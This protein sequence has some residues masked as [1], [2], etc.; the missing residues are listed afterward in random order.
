MLLPLIYSMKS[1]GVI[2]EY[3][4]RSSHI[5]TT[6]LIEALPNTRDD[7]L[8]AIRKFATTLYLKLTKNDEQYFLDKTPRYSLIC[9]EIIEIFPEAK[10]IFLWRNP[11]AI[12]ASM[13]ET[14]GGGRWSLYLFR[15]DLFKGLFKLTDCI[16]NNEDLC[17]SV[18]YEDLVSGTAEWKRILDY[19]ELDFSEEPLTE[20]SLSALNGRLG[21]QTGVQEYKKISAESL[22]KWKLVLANPFR[23]W[24]CRRYLGLLGKER[25]EAMGYNQEI[26]IQEL[27]AAPMTWRYFLS[28]IFFAVFGYLYLFFNFHQLKKHWKNSLSGMSNYALR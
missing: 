28:D 24:W 19:L 15:I 13:L 26:L 17:I 8:E 25:L 1:T 16:R 22:D 6:D 27:N 5:A 4:H 9:D 3:D 12:L 20:F 11:L 7:Y 21:D 23:K 10:Y 18:R 2:S 14:W